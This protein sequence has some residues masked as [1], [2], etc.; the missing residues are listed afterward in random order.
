[1]RLTKIQEIR[2]LAACRNKNVNVGGG[3]AGEAYSDNNNN[4]NDL[5][6]NNNLEP[7]ELIEAN[8]EDIMN[9]EQQY[10]LPPQPTVNYEG[11]ALNEGAAMVTGGY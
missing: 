1:M 3:G 10:N 11:N 8:N 5:N 9:D 4:N 7:I 6:N 2:F